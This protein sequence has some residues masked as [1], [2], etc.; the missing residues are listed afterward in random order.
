[1]AGIAVKGAIS[2]THAF[3]VMTADI[4]TGA[5]PVAGDIYRLGITAAV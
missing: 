4:G 5:E 2:P 1:M 3:S